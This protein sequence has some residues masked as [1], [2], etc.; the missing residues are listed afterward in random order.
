MGE[1]RE[2]D[3]GGDGVGGDECTQLYGEQPDK[4]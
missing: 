3:T 1:K 4:T 2:L